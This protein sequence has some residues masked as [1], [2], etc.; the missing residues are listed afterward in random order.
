MKIAI[1]SICLGK[2]EIFFEEFYASINS[3]FLPQ[4]E[5]IFYIFTD[6]KLPDHKN[7]KTFHQE[8]MGWPKDTMMRF[9]LMNKIK[10]ELILNDYIFF[11]NLNMKAIKQINEE[12]LPR[13]ENDYL[14]GCIHPGHY[15]WPVNS[16]PYERNPKSNCFIPYNTGNFYYQGCFNGGRSL[17]FLK[18]SEIIEKNID[19]DLE[20]NIIPLWHDES[21]LN[22]YYVYKN[23]LT[24]PYSYIAIEDKFG[25]PIMIQRDK[26]KYGGHEFLRS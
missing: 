3:L 19:K 9:H 6:K 20:N 23:P 1:F 15:N 8:K 11:F 12:V 17:E 13:E 25:D 22:H 10:D 26:T 5:K 24:M 4:H 7:L 18:M 16:F 2:Y 21:M 14:M